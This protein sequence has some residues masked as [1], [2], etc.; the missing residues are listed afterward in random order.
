M[1]M[2]EVEFIIKRRDANAIQWRDF[3]FIRSVTQS[4]A[5]QLGPKSIKQKEMSK[6]ALL[7]LRRSQL[8]KIKL[9][10][11]DRDAKNAVVVLLL[12][13]WFG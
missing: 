8:D 12:L 1:R 3:F 13:R 11:E 10:I 4:A 6:S 5:E 9:D 7:R 2:N